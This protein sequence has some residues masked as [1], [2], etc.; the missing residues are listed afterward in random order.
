MRLQKQKTVSTKDSE[1]LLSEYDVENYGQSTFSD[2][3]KAKNGEFR[4]MRS[5]IPFEHIGKTAKDFNWKLYGENDVEYERSLANAFILNFLKFNREGKGLY[6]YSATKGTGKTFLCFCLAN[7][8]MS[9]IDINVKFIGVLEYLE[10]TKKG[11]DS[12][13]DKEEKDSIVTAAVLMLDDVGVAA[14]REWVNTALYQLINYR[15][16]NR[17]VTVITSNCPIEQLKIDDRIKDRI[18]AMCLPLHIPEVPI[19]TMQTDNANR[20][21]IREALKTKS[22]LSE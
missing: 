19:R 10:L 11:C 3:P 9:R 5:M 18:N 7:E 2:R 16:L 15:Y 8:L 6:I 20:E 4:L 13:A 21:F 1:Y 14:S 17:L 22:P 12:I